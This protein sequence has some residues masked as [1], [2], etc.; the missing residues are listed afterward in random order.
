[1]ANPLLHSLAELLSSSVPSKLTPTLKGILFVM[2]VVGEVPL[3]VYD[4]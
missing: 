1:M 3:L 2:T 4:R